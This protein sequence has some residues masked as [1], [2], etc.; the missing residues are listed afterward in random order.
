MRNNNFIQ[1]YEDKSEAEDKCVFIRNAIR[2]CWDDVYEK[3]ANFNSEEDEEVKIEDGYFPNVHYG[4]NVVVA[5]FVDTLAD[6][7]DNDDK[8]ADRHTGK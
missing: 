3:F 8:Y 7:A 2:E 4:I 6:N 5:E 1:H